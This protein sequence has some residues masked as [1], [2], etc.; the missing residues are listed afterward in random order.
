M[1][2]KK[3]RSAGDPELVERNKKRIDPLIPSIIAVSLQLIATLYLA[4]TGYPSRAVT[5]SAILTAIYSFVTYLLNRKPKPGR[6]I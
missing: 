6:E 5:A 4:A 3:V 2:L 1:E